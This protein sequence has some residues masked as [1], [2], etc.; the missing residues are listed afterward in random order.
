MTILQYHP[1]QRDAADLLVRS[2]PARLLVIGDAVPD[3]MTFAGT[4]RVTTRQ[5]P[6]LP[7]GIYVFADDSDATML[8]VSDGE[9]PA[10][11]DETDGSDV[12]HALVHALGWFEHW[13]SGARDVAPPRFVTGQDVVTVPAGQHGVV[14]GRTWVA[15]SWS[16]QVRLEGNL[17]N[18][19]E[20]S[21]DLPP[22][23]DDPADW[24]ARAP[25]S[26]GR[27]AATLTR[28]KLREHLTDTVYSFRASRTL[29]RPYQFRP[30]IRLVHGDRLRL[31][32]AD[33]VGLGKTIEA[34]LVWTELDARNA[35]HRVLVICPSMLVA[36]WCNEMEERFGFDLNRLSRE[37]LD[38]L[39][40]RL[41]GD[42]LPNRFHAICSLE[43]LRT[44]PG[45]ERLLEI[46]P[47]FDLIIVDEAHA[48]RNADTK[49]FALG[50]ALSDW[51]H[52]LIFLSATPLNLGNQDLFNLLQLLA[53][54]DFPSVGVLEDQ[55]RPNAVLNRIAASLLDRE[56]DNVQRRGW[57]AELTQ[58]TFGRTVVARPEFPELARLLEKP[59]LPSEDVARARRLIA[60]LHAL[61]AVVTR[62]RKIEIQ[63]QKAVR[64]A[65][66]IDV[67]WTE[68]ERTLYEAIEDWQVSRARR[69]HLPVGFVTQMPLRLA[70]SCLP[71]AAQSLLDFKGGSFDEDL[72]AADADE[73]DTDGA[74]LDAP[75]PELVALARALGHIDS[76]FDAFLP[77]LRDIVGEGRQVLLFTFSRRTLA[78]L[79]RRLSSIFRIAV[80]HGD[81]KGEQRHQIMREFRQGAYDV[82]LASRVASEGLD[83]EFCSAVVNYDLPWNPMEVEQR[84]G[85]VDRFGQ[86]NEKVLILNFNTPDTIETN[87]VNR[88]YAR[89]GVFKDSIGDLEPILQSELAEIRRTIFDFE[90]TPEQK[91]RRLDQRLAAIEEQRYARAEIEDARQYLS[92]TDNADIDG[93]E[94]ELVSNGR[95]V[96]QPELV[97]L[98]QDWAGLCPGS[99]CRVSADGA[100]VVLRGTRE[101]E[102]HLRAVAA[103][104]ERSAAELDIIARRLL[105]EQ[106]IVVCLDQELARTMGEDL[107]STTHPLTRAA[108]GV[109]GH[110]E[111][112]FS[113][114]ALDA[115]GPVGRFLVVL[116]VARWSG[117]RP[118]SELWSAA[119]DISTMEEVPE[120]GAAL[121]AGLAEARLRDANPVTVPLEALESAQ[122]TL[123]RRQAVEEERRRA[124]N[125]ALLETRQLS[126]RE[127]HARKVEAIERRIDTLRTS[128]KTTTIHL[129]Q[130]QLAKQTR[131]L[132]DKE[133][134]LVT[135]A[136]GTMAV[137]YLAVCRLD[138]G[139]A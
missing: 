27:F 118:S 49:S 34:G 107:L 136:S 116:A 87:I 84:I 54:G 85:R 115:E 18:V 96:G 1:I 60:Q 4:T 135:G 21:L 67:E 70:S 108:L 121:L 130:A 120:A 56:V 76:K 6:S 74:D 42:R 37:G 36:K 40:N 72:D 33:E 19:R 41:E 106:D 59:A 126:L 137:Q 75:P 98:L 63:D 112:R 103:R 20:Q 111:A 13:W 134:E 50:S 24:I 61:S 35:A 44:W 124:E 79:E 73:A 132:E 64:E 53:P 82:L 17:V 11:P 128:G 71:A 129:H 100:R 77:V 10:A 16:Y 43:R 39:L 51:A 48:F 5:V 91:E 102:Q 57:L 62:T 139:S 86:I 66:P 30:A 9:P 22:T 113:H 117:V 90:L 133:R 138:I 93:L 47:H 94:Q 8:F 38:D 125:N 14:R 104:G 7:T 97:L 31:L 68:A 52:A 15:G 101:M 26:A 3:A 80:L 32:I 123:L 45:L 131:L 83:F 95:Y 99:V 28:A 55:L 127:T 114:V 78:Y 12:N 46:S 69:L 2:E 29:F 105:D 92:S 119:I 122:L 23:I 81:V 110:A 88:L 89:I 109:P 25:A 65:V 58:L